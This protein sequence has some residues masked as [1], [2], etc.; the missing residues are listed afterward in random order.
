MP[1][2][3]PGAFTCKANALPL[4]YITILKDRAFKKCYI[5]LFTV[6]HYFVV[7]IRAVQVNTSIFIKPFFYEMFLDWHNTR[8]NGLTHIFL[9]L[10]GDCY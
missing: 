1:G 2:I 10:W 8:F 7:M 3:V 4:S 6:A 9:D 5:H